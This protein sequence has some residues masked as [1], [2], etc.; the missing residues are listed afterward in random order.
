MT[1]LENEKHVLGFH[2]SGHPL[3][4]HE[5]T[6]RSFCS[7]STAS[8]ASLPQ[9]R[10]VTV[11]G[12]L[13]RVRLTVARRGRSAGQ[14]MAMVTVQD[15]SGSLEGVVFSSV[16][17]RCAPQLQEGAV[18]VLMGSVDRRQGEAQLIV[19]DVQPIERAAQHLAG[20]IQLEFRSDPTGESIR[21]RMQ[22]VAGVLKNAHAA[23]TIEDGRPATVVVCVQTQG[24]RI[25]LRC[26]RLQAV[27]TPP[28]LQQLRELIGTPNVRVLGGPPPV[29]AERKTRGRQYRSAD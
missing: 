25:S 13:S 8:I 7:G 29:S 22:M 20:E 27:A 9:D 2:V 10:S 14:K 6:V 12:I 16:F 24:K 3:D 11:A 17:A 28:L 15:K 19:E 5:P 21:D 18:V 1:T 26:S 23:R 4:D